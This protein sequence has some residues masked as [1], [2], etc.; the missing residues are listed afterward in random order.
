ME[1]AGNGRGDDKTDEIVL[2]SVPLQSMSE[3]EQIDV[4]FHLNCLIGR[5]IMWYWTMHNDQGYLDGLQI[6][7]RSTTDEEEC[8]IQFVAIASSLQIT[9]LPSTQ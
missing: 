9:F 4:P 7:F 1:V 3:F 8:T 5:R 6:D 2:S